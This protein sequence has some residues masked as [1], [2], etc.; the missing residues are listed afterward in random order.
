MLEKIVRSAC[1]AAVAVCGVY[2]LAFG[3]NNKNEEGKLPDLVID[4]SI[5]ES[6]PYPVLGYYKD[7]KDNKKKPYYYLS[8]TREKLTLEKCLKVQ[9]LERIDFP[10]SPTELSKYQAKYHAQSE[11]DLIE[12]Q[13]NE[14][15]FPIDRVTLELEF[16]C[17]EGR[18]PSV[19][20]P[21]IR[22]FLTL[23]STSADESFK[24]FTFKYFFGFTGIGK[25]FHILGACVRRTDLTEDDLF[26]GVLKKEFDSIL[27]LVDP[28]RKYIGWRYF[29]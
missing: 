21:Q 14:F 10:K 20:F 26:I 27:D 12:D 3:M 25:V 18:E 15:W 9:G 1:F 7:E 29:E 5:G 6:R 28:D 22:D 19:L 11:S 4:I 23:L 8:T 17:I 24:L 2:N 16:F 13:F